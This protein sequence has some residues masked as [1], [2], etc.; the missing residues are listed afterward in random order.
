M[1]ALIDQIRE[2][3]FDAI[4]SMA[5]ALS[6]HEKMPPPELSHE[7]LH[8]VLFGPDAFVEG[9]IARLEEAVG[10]ALWN[11]GYD[12]QYGTKTLD[13]VDLFVKPEHRRRGIARSLMREMAAVAAERGYR[14]MTVKTFT[15][16]HEANAFYPACGAKLDNCNVYYFTGKAMRAL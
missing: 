15:Q 6:A 14:F 2:T 4:L 7:K 10:Y 8:N 13:I 3:D 11:V 1:T 12:M 5:A 9:R 16:N